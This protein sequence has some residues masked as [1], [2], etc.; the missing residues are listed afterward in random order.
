MLDLEGVGVSRTI[1]RI[2]DPIW[3]QPCAPT[4]APTVFL[5]IF[6]IIFSSISAKIGEH[7]YYKFQFFFSRITNSYFNIED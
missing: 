7:F 2:R 3:H 6:W 4:A 5:Q 1:G